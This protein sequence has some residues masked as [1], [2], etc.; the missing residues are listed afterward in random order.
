MD[1]PHHQSAYKALANKVWLRINTKYTGNALY[2]AN[3]TM[4]QT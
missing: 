2:V 4:S 3:Y 1:K